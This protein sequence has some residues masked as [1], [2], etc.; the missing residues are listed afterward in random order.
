MKFDC[1]I[2]NP[3]Y[4]RNLHL[5]ILAEAITHL[6][7]ETSTCVNLSPVRWLQDPINR[8][9]NTGD[10]KRF[11]ESI[12]KH[13]I[14]LDVIDAS[15]AQLCFSGTVLNIDLGIYACNNS[16]NSTFNYNE[17]SQDRILTKCEDY[18]VSHNPILD[19][20]KQNGWRVR[21]PLILGGKSGGS[22]DRKVGL[23]GFGKLLNFNNGKYKDGKWWYECYVKNQYSKTTPY[24]TSS[25]HFKTEIESLNFISQFNTNFAKYIINVLVSDVHVAPEKILWMGDAVNPRTGKKGYEGEWTDSDF[26]TFFNITPD[27]QKIIESTME[28]YK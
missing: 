15:A 3:P 9:K 12:C 8:I 26:Y 10:Y 18:I 25:I 16:L 20:N 24:I 7:D 28:K 6:K 14:S 11:N 2:M 4:E 1:I 19:K 27:E 5:K 23:L 17:L 22:G 21:M 13:L